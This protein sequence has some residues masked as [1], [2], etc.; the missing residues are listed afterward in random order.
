[1]LFLDLEGENKPGD[2]FSRGR[3]SVSQR[4]RVVEF[5]EF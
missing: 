4:N 2:K 1:M 5:Q 3:M